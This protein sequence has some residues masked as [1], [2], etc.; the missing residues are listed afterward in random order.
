MADSS[1]AD[2]TPGLLTRL[3]EGL[4]IL[5]FAL[6][7][8]LVLV[9]SA[10]A[11]PSFFAQPKVTLDHAALLLAH[12]LRYAQNEAALC[13]QTTEVRFDPAGDG[14]SILYLSGQAVANPIGGGDLERQYSYDAVFRGVMLETEGGTTHVRFDRSGFALDDASFV[15]HYGDDTRR[16]VL[17]RGSG[18]MRIEGLQSEWRDDGL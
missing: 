14:Y 7:L 11:I 2:S 9:V 10:I 17:E 13:A 18:L 5:D 16:L 4:N 1:N 6:A 12:D 15:L 3:R 8:V